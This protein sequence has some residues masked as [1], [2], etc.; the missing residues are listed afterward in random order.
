MPS[1]RASP[2]CSTTD[3]PRAG[4]TENEAGRVWQSSPP[5]RPT[6][7][8]MD[9]VRSYGLAWVCNLGECARRLFSPRRAWRRSG[10]RPVS[11]RWSSGLRHSVNRQ[12]FDCPIYGHADLRHTRS[13]GSVWGATL[14]DRGAPAVAL[15]GGR[16][17]GSAPR[18]LELDN[19]GPDLSGPRRQSKGR[20]PER[21]WGLTEGQAPPYG[22][23]PGSLRTH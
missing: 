15:G 1:E 16:G 5:S 17:V 8:S 12:L 9:R 20:G 4:G 18:S 19:L 14:N 21:N 3:Q 22:A 23:L 11:N 6:G 2:N 10:S 13:R 7:P